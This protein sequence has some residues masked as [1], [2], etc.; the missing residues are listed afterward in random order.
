LTHLIL[1]DVPLDML[2]LESLLA[3]PDLQRPLFNLK[4]DSIN[5]L[6]VHLFIK[7]PHMAFS[8]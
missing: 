6:S 4:I 5:A 7:L 8:P 2:R 3:A 1:L